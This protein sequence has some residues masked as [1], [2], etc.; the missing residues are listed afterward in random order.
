M[1]AVEKRAA[2]EALVPAF[3][4][5]PVVVV[6]FGPECHLARVEGIVTSERGVGARLLW[7]GSGPPPEGWSEELFATWEL[8]IFD[9]AYWQ[10][11]Y[12]N[13]RIVFDPQC[14]EATR[15]G[16]TAWLDDFF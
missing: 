1:D 2:F 7:Q 4:G 6:E 5:K 12:A 15:R 10:V 3:E 13:V 9:E 14:V 11:M 16:D 8:L